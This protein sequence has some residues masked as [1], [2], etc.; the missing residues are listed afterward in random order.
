[1]NQQEKKTIL[2]IDDDPNNIDILTTDLEDE[3]YDILTAQEGAEGWEVLQANKAQI[4]VI[5]LDR[6]MPNVDGMEF[7]RMLKSDE[8]VAHKPVIMIT[9]AAEKSQIAE[10]IKMGVYYYLTKPYEVEIMLAVVRAAIK[11]YVNL[12]DLY[13]SLK[14]HQPKLH[15]VKE[16]FFEVSTL[17]D[18]CYLSTFLANHYPDP[19]RVILGLSELLINAIEHGNLGITYQQKSLLLAKNNW[20]AEIIK[21]QQAPEYRD[22]KVL[23]HFKKEKDHISLHIKDDGDGFD[24]EEYLEISP[25]RA[26]HSHGRGI[27]LSNKISFDSIEY[28]GKGNEVVCTINL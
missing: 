26:T 28:L 18:A 16:S 3:G 8:S 5:L 1:M 11:D 7:M 21:R 27:A 20:E 6:M 19:D 2:I 4:N 23:V 24:W 17:E 22:K 25:D 15:I 14:Q 10:G 13:G 12:V 9:A